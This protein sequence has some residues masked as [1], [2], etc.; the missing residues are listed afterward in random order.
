MYRAAL[1]IYG[2]VTMHKFLKRTCFM[3]HVLSDKDTIVNILA[4]EC[5]WFGHMT[6]TLQTQHLTQHKQYLMYV[7][8][9]CSN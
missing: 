3:F 9:Y 7:Q 5:C 4:I 2:H 6:E 8:R 1:T